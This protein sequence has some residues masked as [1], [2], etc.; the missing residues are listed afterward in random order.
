M[1][2][3]GQDRDVADQVGMGDDEFIDWISTELGG[4]DG[5]LAVCLGGSRAA[6]T[7]RPE[8]DWDF[9]IYYRDHFEPDLLRAKGWSG[10]VFD[11][12]AWGGG[13]MNGGAW[14]EI[15]GRRVDIHYRDL[16]EVEHWCA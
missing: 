2:V 6:G 7:H 3:A 9:A 13:V 11:V 8:S 4:L 14:L 10:E 1:A 5:V 16:N 15:D 12:G